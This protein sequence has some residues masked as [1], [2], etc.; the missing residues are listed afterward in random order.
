MTESLRRLCVVLGIAGVLGPVILRAHHSGFEYAQT[1]VE[2]EGTLVSAT[3][4]NPHVH[5]FVRAKDKK[6][7]TVTWDI[8]ANSLTNLRGTDATPENMKVGD[9][10]KVAGRPSRNAPRRI[11]VMNILTANGKE[12]VFGPGVKPRWVSIGPK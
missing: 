10:V 3:W 2:I 7:A 4:E 9:T 1:T 11:W 6:G 12:I 5:F 8:E